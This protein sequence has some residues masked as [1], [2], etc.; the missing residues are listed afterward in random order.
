MANSAGEAGGVEVFYVAFAS[1]DL[2]DFFWIGVE[3]EDVEAFFGKGQREWQADVAE[4]DDGD[5]RAA[6]PQSGLQLGCVR[7]EVQCVRGG[8]DCGFIDTGES[9]E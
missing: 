4:A 7:G 9:C 1:V 8:Q 3:A 6:V 2:V 5:G